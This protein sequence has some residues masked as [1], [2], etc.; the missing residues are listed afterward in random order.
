MAWCTWYR[1]P[2]TCGNSSGSIILILMI[3]IIIIYIY[4]YIY[5]YLSINI[6][7]HIS[8][9]LS[10]YLSIYIYILFF[11]LLLFF[12]WTFFLNSA[13]TTMITTRFTIALHAHKQN[14]MRGKYIIR[15]YNNTW[16][17]LHAFTIRTQHIVSHTSMIHTNSEQPTSSLDRHT[18]THDHTAFD[19]GQPDWT[20]ASKARGAT[21]PTWKLSECSCLNSG[22]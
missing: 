16:N 18:H 9:Y 10:I 15:M 17:Q 12:K 4:L 5:I 14:V 19:H 1:C 3:I 7:I 8:I 22:R 6:Y 13:S 20:A 11:V 21:G 2:I